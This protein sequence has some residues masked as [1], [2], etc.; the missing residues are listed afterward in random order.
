[1]RVQDYR[2]RHLRLH[3]ERKPES[4][5]KTA[6]LPRNTHPVYLK[7]VALDP[8]FSLLWLEPHVLVNR[9]VK[10]EVAQRVKEPPYLQYS[11]TSQSACS[12]FSI[13]WLDQKLSQHVDGVHESAP[14]RFINF[15]MSRK[16]S[17]LS[18]RGM[19]TKMEEENEWRQKEKDVWGQRGRE[20]KVWMEGMS[21]GL[22]Q[23][24][25]YGTLSM[26]CAEGRFSMGMI[27]V[28]NT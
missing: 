5:D 16:F 22:M 18:H 14:E 9:D 11:H 13:A 7:A 27:A 4:I 1:M 26:Y 25:C 6:S 10:V 2:R 19:C 17:I 21:R 24:E 15:K 8:A 23:P 12:W 20:R 3:K 28:T